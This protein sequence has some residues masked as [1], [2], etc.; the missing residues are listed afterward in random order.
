MKK[1]YLEST[2]PVLRSRLD[3]LRSSRSTAEAVWQEIENYVMPFRGEFFK[4]STSETD[5]EWR[6]RWIYDST[7]VESA[8]NLASS[9]NGSLTLGNWFDV[10]FRNDDLNEDKDATDWLEEA[11][12]IERGALRESNFGLESNE[13]YLDL[14]GFGN[15]IIMEEIDGTYENFKGLN[16]KSVPIKES[17]FEHNY[18]GGAKRFY[19]VVELTAVQIVDKFGLEGVPSHIAEKAKLPDGADTKYEVVFAIYEREAVTDAVEAGGV[20]LSKP[21]PPKNRPFGYRWFLFETA[22]ELDEEGG[23]YEMPVFIVRW[24]KVSG[25]QWGYGPA[26]VAMGDILTLNQ[27]KDYVLQALEKVIDPATLAEERGFFGDLDLGPGG[28]N[29]VTGVDK[30]KPYES[31]ARFDVS[32]METET[33]RESIR[34]MFYV[35]QLQLKESP[36]MTA[37]EVQVRYELMNRLLGPTMG[38]LQSD[39][40]DPLVQRTF[41]ILYRAG[42]LP[43]VPASVSEQKAEMDVEYLGPLSRAQKADD[44]A[45]IERFTGSMAQVMEIYP[46]V[47]YIIDPLKMARESATLLGVPSKLIRSEEDIE[48]QMAAEQKKQQAAET[49]QAAQAGG[50]AMQSVAKGGQEMKLMQ[51]GA[52]GGQAQPTA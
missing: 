51:G 8:Q 23:Y 25:S 14:V 21:L 24:R 33:L 42:Q 4:K 40:L 39:F 18:K 52:D 6:K 34:R 48:K 35:D 16:F 30:I 10:R 17:Y 32:K 44:V 36:Q 29:I 20:D 15:A 1:T 27:T 7:P 19:R 41:N 26:H 13:M 31:G 45:A 38:R 22:E 3:V 28:I 50:D 49:I 11:V 46:E 37:T 9:L 12:N 47:R 2:C 43:E 5:V